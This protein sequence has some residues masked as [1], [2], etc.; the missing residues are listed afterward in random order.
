MR[1]IMYILLAILLFFISIEIFIYLY[2]QKEEEVEVDYLMILGC[3]LYGDK[4]SP[5]LQ[6]RVDKGYAYAMKH[7]DTPIIVSG[8]KGRDEKCSEAFAMRQYL[9]EKG[10]EEKR[11]L[12]E[13][14]S[15]C[16]FTNFNYTKR[17]LGSSN[18]K[19][20]VTTCDFHMY[21]SIALGRNAGFTCYRWPAKSTTLH[22][23]KNF[24]REFGCIIY[25]WIYK[26]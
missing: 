13:D 3:G 20:L 18:Y 4:L 8:G 23:I 25:F 15:V 24:I 11:I 19:I 26:K 12:M 10:I 9:I 2:G 21:R 14:E 17:M 1:T 6:R 16:T 5:A 22:S 7:K